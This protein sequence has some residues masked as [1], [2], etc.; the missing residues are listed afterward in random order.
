MGT[1]FN[2]VP[3]TRLTRAPYT[4]YGLVK[5]AYSDR[6]EGIPS[7]NLLRQAVAFRDI[8]AEDLVEAAIAQ[9]RLSETHLQDRRFLSAVDLHLRGLNNGI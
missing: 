9:G 2:S 6:L 7:F 3:E 8:T 1:I 5:A 4:P